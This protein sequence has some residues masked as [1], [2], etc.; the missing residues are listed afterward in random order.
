MAPKKFVWIW[1]TL[2]EILENEPDMS[3]HETLREAVESYV[4]RWRGSDSA[5]EYRFKERL[6]DPEPEA[7]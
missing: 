5:Y 6:K 3:Q 2:E 4:S 1:V 7:C